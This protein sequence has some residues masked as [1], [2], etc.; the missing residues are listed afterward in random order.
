MKLGLYLCTPQKQVP[1][2]TNPWLLLCCLRWYYNN[3]VNNLFHYFF[4]NQRKTEDFLLQEV[5][6]QPW[7]T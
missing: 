5:M 6:K 2:L 1:H 7:H 3:E 4:L